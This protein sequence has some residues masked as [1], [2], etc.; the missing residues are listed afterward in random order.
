M[1]QDIQLVPFADNPNNLLDDGECT[2]EGECDV[3]DST[4][5]SQVNV[6][7]H[8]LRVG[9]YVLAPMN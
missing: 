4:H 3:I 7:F 1:L 8:I 2:G 6:V 5:V 9:L